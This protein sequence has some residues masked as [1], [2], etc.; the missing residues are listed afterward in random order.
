MNI[1]VTVKKRKT[2]KT[3]SNKGYI[4]EKKEQTEDQCLLKTKLWCVSQC[5]STFNLAQ[6]VLK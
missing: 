2:N 3:N 6:S 4:I 1:K 5:H